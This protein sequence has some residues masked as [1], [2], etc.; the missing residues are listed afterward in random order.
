MERKNVVE[1]KSPPL[2]RWRVREQGFVLEDHRSS[3]GGTE[4]DVG[5]TKAPPLKR[6]NKK[7]KVGTWI[8]TARAVALDRSSGVFAVTPYLF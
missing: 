7:E 8:T 5:N 2:E 6:W 4:W 1:T 3:G